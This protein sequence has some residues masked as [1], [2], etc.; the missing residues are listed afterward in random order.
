M[1]VKLNS[2]LILIRLYETCVNW[3]I[4]AM[5]KKRKLNSKFHY[6]GTKAKFEELW[7]GF[8]AYQPMYVT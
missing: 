6:P 3:A 8:M 2:Y 5:K 1:Q 7:F 4:F